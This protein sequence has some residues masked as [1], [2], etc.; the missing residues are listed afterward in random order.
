[1]KLSLRFVVPLE[2]VLAGFAY[3]LAPL[4]DQLTLRWFVRDLEI[5]ATLIVSTIQEP[6]QEQLAAGKK[7]EIKKF[8]SR[9]SQDERLY[10]VGYCATPAVAALASQSMPAEIRCDR[11]QRWQGPGEHL[12]D[13]TINPTARW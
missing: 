12:L 5:R 11:L 9:I 8:F 2:L 10:A 4:I 7:S 3:S 1:M 6:L 13:G